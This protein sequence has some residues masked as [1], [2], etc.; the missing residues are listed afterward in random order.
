MD[1]KPTEIL[2]SEERGSTYLYRCYTCPQTE[3][4]ITH[5]QGYRQA[6]LHQHSIHGDFSIDALSPGAGIGELLHLSSA[7]QS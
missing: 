6:V 7:S 4:E 5:L 3:E 2:R 1:K